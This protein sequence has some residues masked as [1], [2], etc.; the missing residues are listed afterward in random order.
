[1]DPGPW[2]DASLTDMLTFCWRGAE[3]EAEKTKITRVRAHIPLCIPP[4]QCWGLRVAPCGDSE[5]PLLVHPLFFFL[6]KL[7]G[8][9]P[10]PGRGSD[11]STGA[12]THGWGQA[13]LAASL[14]LSPSILFSGNRCAKAWQR[15]EGRALPISVGQPPV[16]NPTRVP[17]L[18]LAQTISGLGSAG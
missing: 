5:A 16:S 17:L 10:G 12:G 8:F 14:P 13:A 3:G 11:K 4:W 18:Q 1:M 9:A 7:G 6:E 15:S 2:R